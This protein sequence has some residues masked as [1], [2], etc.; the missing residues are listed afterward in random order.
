MV[1]AFEGAGV[2]GHTMR[3]PGPEEHLVGAAIYEPALDRTW[4]VKA[5]GPPAV[6][7]AHAS[8]IEAF[9]RS[10]SSV[11]ADPAGEAGSVEGDG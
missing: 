8:G 5:V 3:M 10:F 4:F 1:E 11:L 7:A 6:V 2:S 9:S